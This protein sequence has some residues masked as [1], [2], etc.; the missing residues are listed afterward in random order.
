YLYGA[1]DRPPLARLRADG[2]PAWYLA[3]RNGTVRL[4]LDATG[5]VA[6]FYKYDNADNRDHVGGRDPEGADRW[7][8]SGRQLFQGQEGFYYLDGKHESVV[9]GRRQ[10]GDASALASG[11]YNPQRNV[12][13]TPTRISNNT[14]AE[15]INDVLGQILNAAW[16]D[17]P[18]A[19][20][21][22][23]ELP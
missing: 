19:Q 3:D 9:T 23:W 21:N 6:T 14:V 17:A 16:G 1:Q 10:G 20:L 18:Q 2:T 4:L 15:D 13:Y 12:G 5:Q 11:D 8:S 22:W 7:T